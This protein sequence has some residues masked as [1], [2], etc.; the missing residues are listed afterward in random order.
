[1]ISQEIQTQKVVNPLQEKL[2]QISEDLQ[3]RALMAF[4]PEVRDDDES[5]KFF[6]AYPIQD[7]SP[8][9][10]SST[11]PECMPVYNAGWM[12][13][14]IA[15]KWLDAFNRGASLAGALISETEGVQLGNLLSQMGDALCDN[16]KFP[17]ISDEYLSPYCDVAV[18]VLANEEASTMEYLLSYNVG[19]WWALGH[20]AGLDKSVIKDA[21]PSMLGKLFRNS[22]TKT[23]DY[24]YDEMIRR[25]NLGVVVGL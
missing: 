1:M 6:Y 25:A 24:I 14:R 22:A 16:D 11:S 18:A 17:A 12:I 10:L 23:V 2:E 3:Y 5:L 19:L 7:L 13:N 8:D 4:I 9:K 15:A 20:V 21:S